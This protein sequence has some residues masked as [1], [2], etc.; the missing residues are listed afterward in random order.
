MASCAGP[1]LAL[2]ARGTAS[3]PIAVEAGG[4]DDG[5][6]GSDL[7]CATA[8]L[9][10]LVLVPVALLIPPGCIDRWLI[11]PAWP[12][13]HAVGLAPDAPDNAF[14]AVKLREMWL[15]VPAMFVGGLLVLGNLHLFT[16]RRRRVR[17]NDPPVR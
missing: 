12:A 7:L 17:R 6:Q 9:V 11:Q 4:M 8:F 5:D 13:L 2:R 10:G 15:R 14:V 3:C 1:G 16:N